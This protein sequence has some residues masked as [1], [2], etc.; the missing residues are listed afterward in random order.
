MKEE[1]V[2]LVIMECL[3]CGN[4]DLCDPKKHTI[5]SQCDNGLMVMPHTV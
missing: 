4:R 5:C 1:I 3:I 2:E